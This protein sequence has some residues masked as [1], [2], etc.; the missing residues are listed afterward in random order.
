M[1]YSEIKSRYDMI[2]D[3]YAAWDTPLQYFEDDY[4]PLDVE[5]RDRFNVSEPIHLWENYCIGDADEEKLLAETGYDDVDE[6][7]SDMDDAYLM[8]LDDAVDEYEHKMKEKFVNECLSEA[9]AEFEDSD[10]HSDD[11]T[12]FDWWCGS[13]VGGYIVIEGVTYAK[14]RKP[15]RVRVYDT[16]NQHY[17]AHP[18][19]ESCE[20]M[21]EAQEGYQTGYEDFCMWKS[22]DRENWEI[23]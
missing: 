5:I 20:N 13:S 9:F 3:E 14:I 8:Q 16:F 21:L 4:D 1:E 6:L 12:D 15:V 22:E 11:G 19:A 7:F 23:C 10:N 2:M 18:L 17:F